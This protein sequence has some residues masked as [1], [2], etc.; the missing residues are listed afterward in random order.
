[1]IS[2]NSSVSS[3]HRLELL[4]SHLLRIGVLVAG[5]LLAVGWVGMWIHGT[6]LSGNLSEYNPTAFTD[7]LQWAIIMQDRW[8]LIS[9]LGLVVLVLLP[10]VRVFLTAVLFLKQKDFS[11]ALMAFMVF[12]CLLSS[13]FL[14]I[15]IN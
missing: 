9:L 2:E 6:D 10:L 15:D 1:M 4:V 14:G 13:F 8:L 3:L 5:G 7:S 11:L 12:A